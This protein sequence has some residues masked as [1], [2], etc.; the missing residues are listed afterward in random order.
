MSRTPAIKYGSRGGLRGT[1]NGIR[2]V[3]PTFGKAHFATYS[4]KAAS[5]IVEVEAEQVVTDILTLD[6]GVREF[7]GQP[8]TVDLID[9]RILRSREQLSEARSKH[10]DLPRPKFYTP[11]FS[12]DCF[13]RPPVVLEVKAEGYEGDHEYARKLSQGRTFLEASGYRFLRVV[14]PSD[15]WHPLRVNLGALS[16]AALR[17]D[18]WPTADQARALVDACGEHG[19][20]LGHI[21]DALG[22]PAYLTPSWLV[23]GIFAANLLRHPINFDLHVVPARGDLSH[24]ALL[25]E[26]AK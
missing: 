26:L 5:C 9:R 1:D 11:D 22:L 19:Q 10:N 15:A 21:C 13:D 24:L 4:P 23:S 18:L 3:A 2:R 25:E 7:K 8:F 17:T 16:L 14:V 6:P 20:S 12:V